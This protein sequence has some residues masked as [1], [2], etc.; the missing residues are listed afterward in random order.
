MPKPLEEQGRV[1]RLKAAPAGIGVVITGRGNIRW[2]NRLFSRGFG[3][4]TTAAQGW[5][6]AQGKTFPHCP[7]SLKIQA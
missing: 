4:W 5:D 3:S 6:R 2:G 7:S 1:W